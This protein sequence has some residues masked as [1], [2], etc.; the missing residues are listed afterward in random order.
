MSPPSAPRLSAQ[1]TDSRPLGTGEPLH[2]RVHCDGPCDVRA[3]ATSFVPRQDGTHRFFR[4]SLATS[5]TL[6]AG[7]TTELSLKPEAGVNAAGAHGAPQVPISLV[8]CIPGGAVADRLELA[9]PP[10]AAS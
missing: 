3:V 2:V 4:L 7:G 8:A 1:L 5:A 9:P 10:I 6:P